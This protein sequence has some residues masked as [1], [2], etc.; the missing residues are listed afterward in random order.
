M[1]KILTTRYYF[2]QLQ[3]LAKSAENLNWS[4]PSGPPHPLEI[5]LKGIIFMLCDF[6]GSGI[7]IN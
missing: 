4:L 2:T 6:Y 5:N 7:C 1:T 3:T